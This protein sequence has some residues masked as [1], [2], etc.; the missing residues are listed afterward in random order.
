MPDG[1]NNKVESDYHYEYTGPQEAKGAE[2]TSE[3]PFE[4]G[5]KT[6]FKDQLAKSPGSTQPPK[7]PPIDAPELP[8][9]TLKAVRVASVK[10][11]I[12]QNA[13]KNTSKTGSSPIETNSWMA[14]PSWM[15]AFMNKNMDLVSL[16]SQTRYEE[17]QRKQQAELHMAIFGIETANVSK[18]EKLAQ[19]SKEKLAAL[20]HALG[21]GTAC[22]Q[23]VSTPGA[24]GKAQERTKKSEIG[25][26]KTDEKNILTKMEQDKGLMAADGTATTL[27]LEDLTDPADQAKI[28]DQRKKVAKLEKEERSEFSRN[29][30]EETT[31]LDLTKRIFDGSANGAIEIAKSMVSEYESTLAKQRGLNDVLLQSLTRTNDGNNKAKDDDLSTI[32]KIYDQMKQT[33]EQNQRTFQLKG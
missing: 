31:K 1:V 9:P 7:T 10:R 21:A 28:A 22:I 17:S 13:A 3:V 12:A 27:K 11:E 24:R 16:V 5:L 32:N 23:L 30:Q 20:G 26:L 8:I 29:L 2:E 25:K 6:P 19:A 18:E 15:V 14:H 4:G 33:S